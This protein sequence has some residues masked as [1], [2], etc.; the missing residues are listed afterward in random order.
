M[1]SLI[2]RCVV[3]ANADAE[4]NANTPERIPIE[5]IRRPTVASCASNMVGDLSRGMRT[6]PR[7]AA[8]DI[9]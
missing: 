9:G 4:Q 2:G 8:M 7:P 1:K 6:V 5:A 3:V